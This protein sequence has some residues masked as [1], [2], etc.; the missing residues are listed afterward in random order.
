MGSITH[1]C[2]DETILNKY[3]Y[4]AWGEVVNQTETIQNRFKFNGQQLDPI[5]QQ[6][7]L[8]A[9]YYNP[10]IARFTQEDTYRG[11]GLNLYAYC[12]NNPVMYVDPSGYVMENHQDD[13]DVN[14]KELYLNP[15]KAYKEE[16][17][18]S[19]ENFL[20]PDEARIQAKLA[21]KKAIENRI[22]NIEKNIDMKNSDK[23]IGPNGKEITLKEDFLNYGGKYSRKKLRQQELYKEKLNS[24]YRID[25]TIF[26]KKWKGAKKAEVLNIFRTAAYKGIRKPKET[27]IVPIGKDFKVDKKYTHKIKVKSD[28]LGDYRV[29]GYKK[30]DG[31][32][33]FDI[34]VNHDKVLEIGKGN[35][36]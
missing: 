26:D 12:V 30:S 31:T 21:S 2:Q 33:I 13:K 23:I 16:L 4:D 32:W 25:D 28:E 11:D 1:I 15:K 14:E 7:Y 17:I 6:Y 24:K 9:K 5:T 29:L 3:E 20:S 18:R 35:L 8:R 22:K 36:Q 10:V 34:L 19:Q 27:G